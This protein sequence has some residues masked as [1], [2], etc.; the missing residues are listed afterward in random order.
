M[1]RVIFINEEWSD[2]RWFSTGGTRPK[3][4]FLAPNGKYYFFKRSEFKNPIDGKQGKDYKYEFWNEVIA[5]EIGQHLG[6]NT[7]KYD[8]AVD[9]DVVG[10]ISESMINSTRQELIEG[11]KYLQAYSPLYDP[12]QKEHKRRY[13][14]SFIIDALEKARIDVDYVKCMLEIIVFDAL[15]GNGD[16]HQENWAIIET[17]KLQS[18]VLEEEIA[19]G[20]VTLTPNR[21]RVFDYLKRF[22]KKIE[23]NA[24]SRGDLSSEYYDIRHTF[25]PIYDSGSSLG[26]ELL[27]DKIEQLITS[28]TALLDYIEKG[29]SEIHWQNQK[30]SHFDLIRNLLSTE[31]GVTIRDTLQRV[32]DKFNPATIWAII[33]SVD[34]G[35][36]ESLH[37]YKIPPSRKKLISKILSLRCE[38]LKD[39][40]HE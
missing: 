29:K 21:E 12:L 15:I 25:A 31:H 35:V 24:I 27:D 36:P 40:L 5:Y 14:F 17:R 6:F 34:A 18:E 3:K 16:R 8:V 13:E 38:K 19:E 2:L 39:L 9:G 10:C 1:P 32:V 23:R 28:D 33:E 20:K 37:H 30:L 7:L 4:Y 11:I 22:L 26:R